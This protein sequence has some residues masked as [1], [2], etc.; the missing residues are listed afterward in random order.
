MPGIYQVCPKL[1]SASQCALAVDPNAPTEPVPKMQLQRLKN[2][3]VTLDTEA[4]N[5]QDIATEA[6]NL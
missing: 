6:L 5:I 1:S 4:W 2:L 3:P